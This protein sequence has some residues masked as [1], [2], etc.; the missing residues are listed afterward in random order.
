MIL[1]SILKGY[2]ELFVQIMKKYPYN[3]NVY[4]KLLITYVWRDESK[5]S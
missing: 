3:E 2:P 1:S 5:I 4:Q